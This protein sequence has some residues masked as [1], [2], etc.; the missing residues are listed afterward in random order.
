M[1]RF[2]YQV[3]PK[4]LEIIV[5]QGFFER[6]KDRKDDIPFLGYI[7]ELELPD[8]LKEVKES[9]VLNNLPKIEIKQLLLRLN[10]VAAN[11]EESK[12]KVTRSDKTIESAAEP[13]DILLASGWYA[14]ELLKPEE[15]A[16]Y[17]N[18][19]FPSVTAFL[20][21]IGA[22]MHNV[23]RS[24]SSREV[25]SWDF[26]T[27]ESK[28]LRS[29]ITGDMNADLV[30]ERFDVTPYKTED[31]FGNEVLYRPFL[32]ED[33]I[34]IKGYHSVEPALLVALIKYAE[35]HKINSEMLLGGGR[36]LIELTESLGQSS[37]FT[38]ENLESYEDERPLSNFACFDLPIPD[39][40]NVGRT[41]YF[42][43]GESYIY[44][45]YTDNNKRLIFS[46]TD[47]RERKVVA[48]FYPEELDEMLTSLFYQAALA[49]GRTNVAILA[50]IVKYRFSGELERDLA[51][52]RV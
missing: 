33:K 46:Y 26:L 37:G 45:I 9:N 30:I 14:A 4:A 32:D 10:Q 22:F 24:S 43:A 36:S 16:K 6:I 50:S 42:I 15:V 21:C 5:S 7:S 35:Q 31:P 13:E 48:E 41:P 1:S 39:I 17:R 52:F 40:S 28:V 12:W 29:R 27:P 25:P 49:K 51:K 18:Y 34:W 8:Y 23:E 47:E 3:Y 19:G 11:L 44:E 38:A 2:N 20:G